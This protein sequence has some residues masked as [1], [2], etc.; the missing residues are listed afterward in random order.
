MKREDIDRLLALY[1][2]DALTDAERKE[3]YAA[4]LQDQALFDQLAEEDSIRELVAMPGAKARLIASLEEESPVAVAPPAPMRWFAWASGLALVFVSG[5][6]SYLWLERPAPMHDVAT[7]RT[8][9]EPPKP[10]TPPAP[11]AVKQPARV[12]VDAPPPVAMTRQQEA[13]LPAPIVAPL[14]TAPP[15]PPPAEVRE[16]RAANEAPAPA[17]PPKEVALA[18]SEAD[19]AAK[20]KV[21]EQTSATADF[22]KA[23]SGFR[24]AAPASAA[25]PKPSKSVDTIAKKEAQA[26]LSAWRRTGDGVWTR[27]PAT[28]AVERNSTV[29][30]RY[31]PAANGLYSLTNA[32][33]SS[34]MSLSG[35]A[36]I[37]LEFVLPQSVLAN[38]TGDSLRLGIAP[39][40]LGAVGGAISSSMRDEA[41]RQ[42]QPGESITIR[43]K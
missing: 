42:T 8:D 28:D 14:P 15:P 32:D 36:G 11:Q 16:R 24:A 35:R 12:V 10:F 20:A 39:A 6:I 30:V 34:L 18:R 40:R 17:G 38:T 2:A 19:S 29:A 41:K 21:A 9:R 23:R 1:A 22:E 37:E 25:A 33:G 5:A 3:L 26:Q 43:L 13:K 31:T 4:A 7:V 27:I